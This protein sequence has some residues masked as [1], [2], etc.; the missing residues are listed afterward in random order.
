[1]NFLDRFLSQGG[2]YHALT[3]TWDRRE[4]EKATIC[5]LYLA[6]KMQQSG[7]ASYNRLLG[8]SSFCLTAGELLRFE[9]E[10]STSLK[11]Y[12][13]PPTVTAFIHHYVQ[14]VEDPDIRSAVIRA[15]DE[16]VIV[17]LKGKQPGVEAFS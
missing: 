12:L 9:M 3:C 10:M 4:F 17:S 13:N 8:Y 14:F 16:F 6:V 1:M 7:P 15:A 11:W 2:C 5:S